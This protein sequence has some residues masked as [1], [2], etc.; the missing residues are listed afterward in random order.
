MEKGLSKTKSALDIM[1][2]HA[3]TMSV[4]LNQWRNS[5]HYQLRCQTQTISRSRKQRSRKPWKL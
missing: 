2:D 3:T 1:A 5:Y 4:E